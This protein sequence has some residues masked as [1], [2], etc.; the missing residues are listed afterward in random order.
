MIKKYLTIF[1]LMMMVGCGGGKELQKASPPSQDVVSE[2]LT[3]TVKNVEAF[4]SKGLKALTQYMEESTLAFHDSQALGDILRYFAQYYD[5]DKK[6]SYLKSYKKEDIVGRLLYLFYFKYIDQEAYK[7]F[8]EIFKNPLFLKELI[9]FFTSKTFLTSEQKKELDKAI[10]KHNES[11]IEKLIGIIYENFIHAFDKNYHIESQWEDKKI[12]KGGFSEKE[13]IGLIGKKEKKIKDKLPDQD[14][15][16]EISTETDSIQ[17]EI[18]RSNYY[19][20][21]V[22][23]ISELIKRYQEVK[24]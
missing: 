1:L 9:D 6:K 18:T 5:W 14:N 21:A 15:I 7:A 22:K 3:P 20:T 16:E 12:I 23:F 19:I 24:N 2:N 13:I 10:Q 17:L 4:S 11:E 8:L